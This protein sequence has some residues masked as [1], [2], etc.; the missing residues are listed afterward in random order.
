MTPGLNH[1]GNGTSNGESAVQAESSIPQHLT[2][3]DPNNRKLRV[4]T[5]GAGISGILMAY[6]LQKDCENVEHVIYERNK[7]IGGLFALVSDLWTYLD[8]VC[9][10]FDLRKFM[11]FHTEITGCYWQ[12]EKGEWAVKLRQ[13]LPGQEPREFEDHCH[14]LLHAAGVF[15]RPQWPTIPGLLDK[16]RGRVIHTGQWPADYQE[17]QWANDRVAI[18]GSGA[19]SIQTVPGMQPH[20]KH[21]DVF[22]RTAIWFGVLAGNSGSQAKEYTPAEREEFRRN[23]AALVAHAK[24]IEDAVNGTWGAFYR[25]SKAHEMASGYFRNR[26]GEM[27]KDERLREG[28]TPKFGFGCRR[29][30]P[31]DPYMEAIQQDNVAVHFTHVESCTEDGVVGGDGIERKVDTVVCATGFDNS[32]R[33]HFPIVGKNGVDLREKWAVNPESYLG[34]AVPDMPNFMT[35]IGPTWPIQNGSVMAPLYSVADYAVKLI[36]KTQ[37]ENLRSWVPKQDVTD[38]FNEH[39]QEWAK[40]TVWADNCRSWYKNNETGRVNAIWPGSSLHYQQVI[41]Q[42]RYEDFEL[43]YFD[44][45]PWAHL[46]MGWTIQDRLGPKQADVCPYLSLDNIDP[47]WYKANGGDVE[48][49]KE[50]REI[51]HAKSAR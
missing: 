45:N 4:L 2:W 49:L 24:A 8:K 51:F 41:E 34:L 19:T 29:I 5:I 40:H 47:R 30:T 17:A 44:K 26:M 25:G 14:V 18:I 28:F 10:V 33:P 12:E 20:A 13:Q 23:P 27:I 22:V 50:Q 42:P 38:L 9:T 6:R 31:G 48:A 21:L 11:T 36:K 16:F 3:M 39:V 15:C 32:Y 35:F 43:R 37:N 7:D 1:N 46:G